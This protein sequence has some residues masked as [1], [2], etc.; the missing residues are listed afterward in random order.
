MA[1][2]IKRALP[3]GGSPLLVGVLRLAAREERA[4]TIPVLRLRLPHVHYPYPHGGLGAVSVSL[5]IHGGRIARRI[6]QRQ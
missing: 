3:F 2:R 6:Y 1:A 5:D 4:L